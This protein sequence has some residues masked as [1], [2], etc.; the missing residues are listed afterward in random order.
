R[1]EASVGAS[2]LATGEAD[3]AADI[4]FDEIDRVPQAKTSTTTEVYALIPD[5]MWHPELK[6]Q[7]VRLALAH[8]IITPSG[9]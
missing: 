5:L 8:A 6:K 4:G 2:M 3:W 7:K 9:L 1:S